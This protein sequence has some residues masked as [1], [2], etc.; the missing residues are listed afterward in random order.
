MK[1]SWIRILSKGTLRRFIIAAK[2]R[3]NKDIM[4]VLT[5]TAIR[6]RDNNYNVLSFIHKNNYSLTVI[7]QDYISHLMYI[8]P[9][10]V[11]P[12]SAYKVVGL[13]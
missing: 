10:I 12:K 6:N 13:E 9:L 11:A 3:G 1:I 4:S 5:T 7:K 8:V 2:E